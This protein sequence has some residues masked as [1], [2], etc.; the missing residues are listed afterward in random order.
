MGLYPEQ[1]VL[2]AYLPSVVP[3]VDFAV[4]TAV[5]RQSVLSLPAGSVV[6][7]SSSELP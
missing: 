3:N 1:P 2:P 5:M 7:A 4:M 6:A